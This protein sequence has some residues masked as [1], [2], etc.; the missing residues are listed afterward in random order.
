L[1]VAEAIEAWSQDAT[2]GFVEVVGRG[3]LNTQKTAE[4]YAR[5]DKRRLSDPAE[6]EASALRFI[7]A[8]G[9]TNR[10]CSSLEE[11]HE[12]EEAVKEV[13]LEL[14]WENKIKAQWWR[15]KKSA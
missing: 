12:F 2:I 1:T 3:W 4:W 5:H 11:L 14:H 8:V 15:Q 7:K 10:W 13:K 9:A 6:W